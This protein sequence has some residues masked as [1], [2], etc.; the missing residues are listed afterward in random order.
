MNKER[1][2]K[3]LKSWLKKKITITAGTVVAFL[4]TGSI[5][6][7]VA[8][9][10]N[11]GNATGKGDAQAVA[12]GVSSDASGGGATVALGTGSKATGR[13]SFAVGWDGNASGATSIS[14]GNRTTA[15]GAN[16]V[17]LGSSSTTATAES[18]VAIGKGAVSK[19][20]NAVALGA[21]SQATGA[22]AVALGQ[23]SQATGENASALSMGA[24][25]SGKDSVAIGDKANSA[26][27]RTI[28]IGKNASTNDI[29][30]IAIGNDS[31]TTSKNNIAI[32]KGATASG[33]SNSMALGNG[34][35]ATGNEGALAVG[36]DSNAGGNNGVAVGR[37]ST[38][39]G[40]EAVAIG[41]ETKST[42]GNTVAVGRGA[43]A[44]ESNAVAI[45][46]N[47]QASKSNAV[48]LGAGSQ[49]TGATAV[50][51]GQGSQATGDRA[52]AL[53]MGATAGGNDSVA[54]GNSSNAS[55]DNSIAVG[56]SSKASGV[57]AVAISDSSNAQGE[58]SLAIGQNSMTN[59]ADTIALGTNARATANYALALG[60]GAGATSESSIAVGNT[61]KADSKDAIAI[62]NSSNARRNYDIV[63]GGEAETRNQS[64]GYSIAIGAG[65]MSGSN[66]SKLSR[67]GKD[68]GGVAI[69]T[70]AYT[71]VN[72]GDG[73][74]INSSV[75]I[76]A[77][78][79]AGFRSLDANNMPAGNATDADT[80]DAVV[81]SKA[82]GNTPSEA[83]DKSATNR[84]DY[85]GVDINEGTAVGRN[86]RAIGDQGVALGAQSI[87]GMGSIAIGGNDIKAFANAKYF[88][89][90][91]SNFGVKEVFDHE[92][93][94]TLASK[95]IS[96]QYKELVGEELNTS[97]QSTYAQNGSTVIGM[98]AHSTTPLGTAIGTNALVRKGAFGA[99]AI[100][101]GSQIQA[102]ADAAVAIGMGA[103]A[104]GAYA[105][106]AGTASKAEKSAVATGYQAKAGVSAV[107]V[108]DKSEAV[109][110]S[111]AVG[112]LAK[113]KK[114]ADI[115]VGQG[116]IASGEQGAIAMGLGTQAQGDSS[117]MIGGAN[118][119]SASQQA[120]TFAKATGKTT[121]KEITEK[122]N[123]K[124]IKRKY[125]F[126]E[127]KDTNGT[128]AEAYQELTGNKMETSEINFGDNANK[129][130]H[131]STSLGVHALS[132]GNLGTAIGAS[133]R[134]NAIGS[135]ALGAGA[136]ATKQNA[137]AI[138]TGSTTELVGTRQLSV[139]YNENGE[140][141]EDG[142]KD[143]AYT[144]K[145]AGGINTSEGDVV[146]F[147]SSGAERQLKN[148]AAGR[149]AED[150]TD[151]INGSQLNSITKKIAA[152]FNTSGNVVTGSSGVFTSKKANTDP[153]KKDYETAIRSDD[154]VQLQVGNNLKLDRDETEVE[155]EVKDDFD[156][157]KT[158]KKKIRKADFAYS[159][160][161]VLTNLTS[162]E[163]KDASNNV[164]SITSTGVTVK[165]PGATDANT[166]SLGQNGLNNGGNAISNIAG[167]L[168]DTK[169][170][171]AT[172]GASNAT[173]SQAA[174]IPAEL[175]KVVNNAAT[176]G[177]VLNAGWNL[178]G[179]GTAVDFVKPYDTVNFVKGD[180][181]SVE[182]A[183]TDGKTSTV[184]YSVN[185]GNGLEKDT[186]NNITV[187]AADK[188][189]TVG[190]D[191][192]KVNTGNITNNNG[193]PTVADADKNK[194]ATTE[195][196]A[197]AIKNSYWIASATKGTSS[198]GDD[199]KIK[200]GD[201]VIFDAGK[202]IEIDHS[203]E[204]KFTFKTV[205][206]PEFKNI[207]LNDGTT[208]PNKVSLTPTAGGLKLSKGDA[209]DSPAK[210][211]NVAAG[212]DEKDAVNYKQLQDA[213]NTVS[214][215]WKIEGSANGGTYNKDASTTA[216]EQI[217]SKDDKVR[218]KAGKNIVLDQSGKEF[219]YSLSK[220]LTGLEKVEVV[221]DGKSVTIEPGKTT[222]TD[223]TN[224][225]VSEA[226]KTQIKN[227]DKVIET[228]PE[229]ILVKDKKDGKDIT[230][231]ITANGTTVT[232][233]DGNTS[234]LDGNGITITPKNDPANPV[235]LTK[236]GLDNG[237]NA[238]KN[239]AGNLDGAKTG[240]TAPTIAHVPVNTTDKNAQNYVNPNNAATV[241]DV[242]NAGWNL[243][244]N[245]K[246]V[247]FVKPYDTVN[248][249]N[250]DGTTATVET[251][252]NKVS[253][254]KYSVNLGN[255]LEKDTNNNIT[256]KA[257]DKSLTV[258]AD[259]V[260]VNPAD[261]SLE[262]TNNGLKVKTDGTTI[263]TDGTN[264][265]KVVTGD[266][267]PVTTGDNSGTAKVKDGDT[268][269]IATV[270]S[271]VNAINSAAWKATS[272]IEDK[273]AAATGHTE[274]V[275]EIKAGDTVTFKAGDNLKIKQSRKE[276]TYSLNPEL[277]NLSK[278][279]V[280]DATGNTVVTTPT[281]TT[282]T[283]KDTTDPTKDITTVINAGGTTVTDKD[284]NTTKVDGNGITITP[285]NDPANP[286]KLTKDG[287]NNG[288]NAITNVAGNLKGAKKDTTS[289]TSKA[290][291]PTNVDDIKNNA[292]TV[293]DVLNAGWN[294]Q[295]NGTAKD[296][297]KPYDTVN[298]INGANTTA[299][300]T[301]D[302]DRKVSNVTYNVTGL[303]LTYT[304]EA[305]K[306][307]S[308][309]GDKYYEVDPATGK[310]VID[311]TTNKPK[312]V[313]P[314]DLKTALVNPN[315]NTA[316]GKT[317]TTDPSTLGNVKSGLDKIKDANGGTTPSAT[318]KT[319]GLVNLTNDKVSDNNV[320][321][322]GDLRN[323]GWVVSSD[324][325]TNGT[326]E[327]SAQVRNANEV[328]FVG[329]GLATVSG[330]TDGNV[331]TITV[332]VD[333]GKVAEN[334]PFEYVIKNNDGTTTPVTKVG[335][336]YYD[337]KVVNP[338]GSLKPGATPKLDP[339]TATDDE[340]N[341]LVV[342]AKGD[343][344]KEITNVAGNLPKTHSD[345]KDLDGT[346]V[347]TPTTSQAKPDNIKNIVNNAATVG[348]VLNAGWNLQGNGKAVD[349]VKPYDTVN[350]VDGIGTTV[351]AKADEK[352]TTST[353]KI[354]T[355]MQY[356]DKEGNPVKK[357]DDGKYY[358][359]NEQ[360]EPDK[361]KPA[362]KDP[363]VSLVNAEPKNE[364]TATTTPT[365]LGN[366]AN[367]AGVYNDKVD[368][369]GNPL[370]EVNGK[371]YT[372][373][374]FENGKLKENA[375]ATEPNAANSDKFKGLSNLTN[376]PDSNVATVG[377]LRNMGWV[378]SSDKTT[379]ALG[380][381]YND[382]VRNANEVKFVGKGTTTV[383]GKTVDG[384]RT[385]TV[386]VNDQVST[387]NSKL[388]V[389]YT[390][391]ETKDGNTSNKQVY[392]NKVPEI[393]KDGNPVKNP[394]GTVKMIDG[395]TTTPEGVTVKADGTIDPA[396]KLKI[397]DSKATPVNTS[398]NG[399][400]GT[401]KATTLSNVKGNLPQVNDKD[402]TV[403]GP[404]GKPYT[405]DGKDVTGNTAAPITAEEAADIVK[406][407]G[408]N[409]ATVGDVLNA[410]W[411]LQGNGK[412]VDFVKPYDTVNFVD[413]IGTTVEAKADE[414]GT[415]S[416]IKINTVMQYTDKEGNPVKKA[417]DGKYYPLNE[418]GE[419]DK[420]K[421]A[422]KDPQVS[423]VNAEPKNEKTA[424]TTPTQLGNVANGAGVYND[425]VDDKGNPLTEVNG[426]YYTADKFENGK[427]KENAAAT[428][429]NAANSDKFKGL[430]NLTNAPDSN[431]ATVGDL[432]NMGWVV[433]SDKTTGALGTAY[434]DQ[435]RNANE[436]KFVGKGT[437]TV[438]G[439]TVD[440]VRTIT[441][442]VNDQVST[443]NSKLP[444]VY[445]ISETKDGNT[446]NKQVYPNKVPE[447]GKDGN[448]VK[449]PDGTVKMIDGFTT[450]PEGV[451]VKAD[452]TID[453][454][455]KLKIV[456]SKAT[457]V[458]TSVNGPEGTDKATT[459]SNVKGNLPQVN[460]KDKTVNG[461][462]GKP[463]TKDG[464]DVTGNTAAPITAE[465][466]ADIVK[467][468]GNNAATVGDV[469]NAGWNLQGNGKAVDFVK[470]YDTVNFRDGGNTTITYE[471][472][473][474]TSHMQ[475]NVTGLPVA[476]TITDPATG[477][478]IPLVKVGDTYYPA[479]ADGTPNIEKD[480]D[481]NPTNGYVQA[482][483]GKVYPKDAVT[484]TKNQDGT[485][486]VEPIVG[487]TPTTVNTNLVNPNAATDKQTTTPTQLG[488]VANGAKTFEAKAD[489]NGNPLIKVGTDYYTVDQ[490]D[491]NGQPKAG[492]TPK[493]ATQDIKMGKD[494]K[495]YPADS[496]LIDNKYYPAGSVKNADGTI[497]Q[498][499]NTTPVTEVKPVAT[500]VNPGKAGL[501]DFSNSN[502]TNAATVGDLQNMGW[503]VGTP[504]N[505]YNDQV[506]NAN[507]VDFKGG[508][509]IE[510][511]GK[512][513]ADGTR[514]I[515]V[516]IKEG[517]VTNNVKVTKE[518]GTVIEAIR[519]KDGKLYKKDANG[520]ADKTQPPV[521]PTDKDKVENNGS[522][523]VTGNSVATAIQESGWNVGKAD[524]KDVTKAFE[525]EAK[526][527]DKVNPNDDVKFVDGDNT[528][529]SMVTI[530][531]QNDDGTKKATTYIKTDINRD[532]NIDSV[533][534]GGKNADGTPGKDGALTVK[535]KNGNDRVKV[536]PNGMTITPNK[537]DG[538]PDPDKA[539]SLTDKGLNNG[540]NNI[541]N[542]KSN[543]PQVKDGD[544]KAYDVNGNPIA[545][546]NNTAAPITAADAADLLNPT[547]DG[548]PNPNFAGNN[549]A[550]LSDVLNAGWNLQNNGTEKDFVKPYDTVNFVD[551]TN[552]T[553]VVTTSD[554]GT[555]SKVTYNVSGLPMSYT[556]KTGK[557]VSKIGDKYYPVNEKGE[558]ISEKGLPAVGTN[559]DGKLVD[560]DGNVIEPINTKEN[561]LS[562]NLVNPNVATD[563]QTTTPTQLGNVAPAEISP[564]STQAVNGSQ[565][566]QVVQEI[567]HVNNKV[568]KLG[569][570]V[571]KGLAGAAAM[572]GIEFME[573]GINQATV[574][575]AVGGYRGTHA[576]AV[577]IEAAPTENTRVNA[578]ASLTPGART[579]SMYSVGAS[580]RFNW[581]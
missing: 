104:N 382:Q 503:V 466:A 446:S 15:S 22:T 228:T 435:V 347:V 113:A 436:V 289:P 61:A 428:E 175:A 484:I 106:A 5:G 473:G 205:D 521:V 145:W 13:D 310:P 368:D 578:K 574:A 34:S 477:K 418:Q 470:P 288:G 151:A 272:G 353:I 146:S 91:K 407:A 367:G 219:T 422:V 171:D 254:V 206:A 53:S 334:N 427:L 286:V 376:A 330:A 10:A 63:F 391:S 209:T 562:T 55:K 81:L 267:E 516:G 276:F 537:A 374:K 287:L 430:S 465:E 231:N 559:K 96:Q 568:D 572:S 247:D 502:P 120:T 174:P 44:T 24:T 243:Q 225:T 162:A 496:V 500:P 155:V 298:F 581:K 373:D 437:T 438:S 442:E 94:G 490:L 464:K 364:K 217:V 242:L 423:L 333:A 71:G 415:T 358:P 198:I 58:R 191:G 114:V 227:G 85:T 524:A 117:I 485:T 396:E 293:G 318:D 535:D 115:A 122:I 304:N 200:A 97:Y 388:P 492:E 184:K 172:T 301:T 533:T 164:T 399:P 542:V 471:T 248:F 451:T 378:V 480:K 214:S 383:S 83:V 429:P 501:V 450:T 240:T 525:T 539:V 357:A 292:A 508:N 187:K 6:A 108:G 305:G 296:F 176:V 244:G 95:T 235:K 439:K 161:P 32:G 195:T 163:F 241:G 42:S 86:A 208:K 103:I 410:G 223:G 447:I 299:E 23:G 257:A 150:S 102:N 441:V 215:S 400:E 213:L 31:K 76:G 47:A 154:K 563:K 119:K 369:K 526:L 515:T 11:A 548:K 355:V 192:V 398:V 495:W 245:G 350:F 133:S 575:A 178:Q 284:G 504:D 183:S 394:D 75:A 576:V 487:K 147:G 135:V 250:G 371:Y 380:T 271:V 510:V 579:E 260:K 419:P 62:G 317:G 143:T 488:N 25:A 476:N 156:K 321:T 17:A 331:R 218:L 528:T 491:K 46:Q 506:R 196:V 68:A 431:V 307:V 19:A 346:T 482:N 463:Y 160:N 448:P 142:S 420:T 475:V 238:I 412:A 74:S 216:S 360:G 101:A 573:I 326:G 443:N 356:T 132:K 555:T 425:K 474:T 320:A 343:K 18:A 361:T 489:A 49:A 460:D 186:N 472:D 203:T 249:V 57:Q 351:E 141:V 527:H 467:K 30:S 291:A 251:S 261:K 169:N 177:D 41:F 499:G 64:G 544:K 411:N 78:A 452:G 372:A 98:Q 239:V 403:N 483:D 540:G 449:N 278:V 509:G 259:G 149:V 128:V 462:D 554:D 497:T 270:D 546:K 580:Y 72:K 434:N 123:G 21:G 252:D 518:D 538:T 121:E 381:A 224:T 204:N 232:D 536:A 385:I 168:P 363:Q 129:N 54:I 493:T 226:D 207:T 92:Q 459:L 1:D 126:A 9:G 426:K 8:Y 26:G 193:V 166:V 404:D 229:G 456:D 319:A 116:A 337:T 65:A 144:F 325:T 152:G 84:F 312:E 362:V 327:Y 303:P 349:F 37:K 3:L 295:N 28:A 131:A 541:T 197:N 519:D 202:N 297:V 481:G 432:R 370:T 345:T 280:K 433:S 273:G 534:A 511:I 12:W 285:K 520:K 14:I 40:G 107:A 16:S 309:V 4:I 50:A 89:S 127:T 348:D 522:G 478:Q 569:D 571:N 514:E 558:A 468:A 67:D 332:N 222:I 80:S 340:K 454:A 233:K 397:V 366:V 69:G 48:A 416:T 111:V 302:A 379:G 409:A 82:F 549:A 560:R 124:D 236:D 112:Q 551:G 167:N 136:H 275:E 230:N 498:A 93:S 311:P 246:A 532:I 458:N 406:K 547:K 109:E 7:T 118:I 375:A 553:A 453:P 315:P 180:G 290:D 256:V 457:P 189:L 445:T 100:G 210:I 335:D 77:G 130:G 258:G 110:T 469:L 38:A 221:K 552:T 281:G 148:V 70:G 531:S 384:V 165:K 190:A 377:D 265:L 417:D 341:N 323:M 294:L 211:T 395:F 387:N 43:Q 51:L 408:N 173:K 262:V 234:K 414:K 33:N 20:D 266:I 543:L 344:P 237:G 413:G 79:G 157:N 263:T 440:G 52:S 2:E 201:K 354:N 125:S 405:K 59:N 255:G 300:V 365:Q 393:G 88:I 170:N 424:T 159:L 324:K 486:T 513:T 329:T 328:K 444:V 269:K 529:V 338:D 274:S 556:D 268:G 188:S 322:V 401:D 99:T 390:I 461:P 137:V 140:I 530:D 402:K 336:K 314:K 45:G 567:N 352:G 545:N 339:T 87:A 494:G 421:P 561:P 507:K 66:V 134:A 27:D 153:E 90:N 577:G 392:P 517:T 29:E 455:E 179:D 253:T 505:N 39:S 566:Y 35:S 212:T 279:E 277:T 199:D 182:V 181:T 264:G 308:K 550:T 386:E 158:V 60:R 105:V 139:S 389:V 479:K 56:K 565:L 512:T 282:I 564:T 313:Q 359:L 185:L 557:P 194:I 138:G 36:R 342:N 570:R 220:E 73:R 523:F 283:A 306:P 316:N